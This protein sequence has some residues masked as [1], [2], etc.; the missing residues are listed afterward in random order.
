M[1]R[2]DRERDADFALAV[3]DKCEWATVSVVTPEGEPYGVPV[4]ELAERLAA[5]ALAK[6]RDE[7][8]AESAKMLGDLWE[9]RKLPRDLAEGELPGK[10]A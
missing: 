3:A 5:H 4:P 8:D 9:S 6:A 10:S 7:F 1:R 2:T